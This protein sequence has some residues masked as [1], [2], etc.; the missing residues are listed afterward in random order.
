M[1]S[2]FEKGSADFSSMSVCVFLHSLSVRLFIFKY[3]L[4]IGVILLAIYIYMKLREKSTT[5]TIDINDTPR[6]KPAA[7]PSSEKNWFVV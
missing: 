3:D 7:P 1:Y 5:L 2:W 4:T 6:T